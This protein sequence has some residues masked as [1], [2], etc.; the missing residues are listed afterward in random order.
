MVFSAGHDQTITKL[1]TSHTYLHL[2]FLVRGGRQRLT[3]GHRNRTLWAWL[4]ELAA[5]LMGT[6]W[7]TSIDSTSLRNMSKHSPSTDWPSP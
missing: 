4:G 7:L 2:G 6:T 3:I 1:Q 5:L